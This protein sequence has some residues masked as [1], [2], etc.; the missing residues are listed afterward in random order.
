M[1]AITSIEQLGKYREQIKASVKEDLP[2]VLVCFGTGCRA[3]GARHVADAFTKI[4]EEQGIKLDVNIGLKITGCQGYC[5]NGTLVTL[6]PQGIM[7][8][9]VNPED[10]IEIVEKTIKAGQ[11]VERL[12]YKD[13]ET[14]EVIAK[15]YEIPFYKYQNR[16]VLRNIG[17]IDPT[18]I[19]DYILHGGYD[20]L[21]RALKMDPDTIIS[22][23]EKSGLRGRGGGGFPTGTK[24]R[25]CVA[26]KSDTRYVICNGDEGDPGAFMDDAIMEGNPH[27]V[28]EGMIIGAIA[29]GAH[30]GYIYVRE[31][32]PFAI[33]NLQ[34]AITAAREK[35]FLGQN[36]LGSGFEFDI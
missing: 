28:L 33:K 26:V 10:A 13:K 4:I 19:D 27:V 20:G 12:L 14:D 9:K 30:K 1:G 32:Y 21:A 8:H 29:V 22:A 3:K 16:I 6:M 36:I 2:T 18:N 31:E 7:Y 11:V 23:V 25:S 17:S 35:G 24:W 5:E 34:K 15:Y